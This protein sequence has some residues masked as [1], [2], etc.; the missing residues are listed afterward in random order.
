M[1][2]W[3]HTYCVISQLLLLGQAESG[4]STLQKQFQLMYNPNS[5]EEERISWRAVIY[6][7]ITRPIRRIFEAL[8][9]FGDGED[10]DDSDAAGSPGLPGRIIGSTTDLTQTSPESVASGSNSP[11][12]PQAAVEE[13]QLAAL[14]SKLSPL[15]SAE[16]SLADRLSGGLDVSGSGKGNV[17][18]RSG[19]Q[20]R[21]LGLSFTRTRSRGDSIN[22]RQS[23]S[24]QRTSHDNTSQ[25]TNDVLI[26]EV[27]RLVDQGKD[28]IQELWQHPAVRRLRAKRKLRFEEWAELCVVSSW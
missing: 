23:L 25:M 4:K 7:N 22:G 17:F 3:C 10:D 14:R 18:V 9:A 6:Y 28:D 26:E 24:G 20:A 12:A 5:L 8:D 1:E 15:L 13:A 27:A 16:S 11:P 19:W 2:L 21:S